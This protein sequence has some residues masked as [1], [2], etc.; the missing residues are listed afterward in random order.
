M[1]MVGDEDVA[2]VRILLKGDFWGFGRMLD[3]MNDRPGPDRRLGTL[4]LA[5]LGWAARTR[6][7]N[8]WSHADVTRYAE[9]VRDRSVIRGVP[10]SACEAHLLHALENRPLP[11][12][13][14]DTSGAE[15]ALIM[16]LGGDLATETRGRVLAE[17]RAQ[18]DR[19][20]EWYDRYGPPVNGV[21]QT[22]RRC[23]DSC[24]DSGFGRPERCRIGRRRR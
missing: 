1:V 10:V 19:W 17:A 14:R 3:A 16:A 12:R 4:M 5:T 2:A 18:A 22:K 6:F 13:A 15:F 7:G 21:W 9:R 11:S 23:R 20:L 8:G 24:V